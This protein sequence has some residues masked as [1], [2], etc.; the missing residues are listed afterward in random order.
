MHRS[1]GIVLGLFLLAG[2]LGA[3]TVYLNPSKDNTLYEQPD[4]SKI[5]NGAGRYIFSGNTKE[6]S[7]KDT[8]RALLQFDFSTIPEGSTVTDVSLQLFMSRT[9][10]GTT[11]SKSLHRVTKSWGEA[12]SNADGEEGTGTDAQLDDATWFHR[13]FV[14]EESGTFWSNPGGDFDSAASGS[15]NVGSS[16]GPYT[17]TGTGMVTDAQFWLDNPAANHGWLLRGAE[18]NNQ[19]ETARQYGS[20]ES[21]NAGE[22][23]LLTVTYDTP[24]PPDTNGPIVAVV[25]QNGGETVVAN[26]QT[27]ITWTADDPSG[28]AHVNIYHSM[29]GGISWRPVALYQPHTGVLPWIPPNRPGSNALLRI[30]AEDF[31]Q[32][33]GVD[34]SDGVFTVASPPPGRVPTTLRDFDMPGTQPLELSSSIANPGTCS[35]C[36][37]DYDPSVA[38]YNNWEG[39]MMSLAG[40]DPLFEANLVIANQDASDSGDLCLRCHMHTGW[41]QGRSVPTDGSSML[42]TDKFGVSCDVCHRMVDPV[43]NPGISPTN[44]L[45]I[46]AAMS[47]PGTNFGTGMLHL[48]QESSRRGPFP[49]SVSKHDFIISPFHREAALCGTCHD[50]SN[51]AFENDGSG[52]YPPG[53]LN[54]M[55]TDFSAHNLA[56]V[57]RTYSEWLNSDYNSPNGVYAPRFAGNK[58]DGMV[59]ACQDCHMRDVLG[60]GCNATNA[61]TRP[62]M[63]LHDMTGGSTWLPPLIAA[64]NPSTVDSNAVMAGVARAEYMLSNAVDMALVS[65]GFNMNVAIT[66]QTGHKLPTGYPEGRRMWINVRFYDPDT[67]L[68][69]ESGAYDF[70][71]GV[72]DL[73][74]KI[75]EVKPGIE[76]NLAAQLGLPAG[77]SFHFVLNNAVFKDNRIPPR[78]FSNAAFDAFGGAPVEYAY[79]D[80]QYWDTTA[81]AVPAAATWAE[82]KLYYQSTSKEFVEFLRDENMTD[83][84]GQEIYDLWNDNGKCPPVVMASGTWFAPLMLADVRSTESGTIE[85]EFYAE[86]GQQYTIQYTDDLLDGVPINWRVFTANGTHTASGTTSMFVDDFTAATSGSMSTNA[87]RFYR[88]ISP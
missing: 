50:V 48:D 16:N 13:F 49:D 44:D 76:T 4:K 67:N 70:N 63:P 88:V 8:R 36:H 68:V 42:E 39:S 38:P 10:D 5:S 47:M 21:P 11:R 74:S 31:L 62:D 66:N 51:P 58:V 71:T 79:A 60:E 2:R 12:G 53:T 9:I 57:E 80:G 7:G 77:P 84:K 18:G 73:A 20:R 22:R 17:F 6:G 45:A 82:V 25:Y 59:G 26:Q 40:R 35:S 86:P 3:E 46:L 61:P 32:N 83:S 87:A 69:G 33:V 1:I 56:P 64:L 75:Y 43:Y 23:P 24:A 65:D 27:N 19:S 34:E 54:Q 52:N 81:Y 15:G 14:E 85:I 72:L 30:E 37:G 29:D 78:G 55:A 41:V 28:V